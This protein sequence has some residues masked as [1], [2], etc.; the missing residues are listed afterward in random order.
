MVMIVSSD[1]VAGV[2]TADDDCFL[3]LG[4]LIGHGELR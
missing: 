2:T 4:F 3:S 1:V